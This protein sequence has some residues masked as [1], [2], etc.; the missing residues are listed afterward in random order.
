[1]QSHA[2]MTPVGKHEISVRSMSRAV[3]V[4]IER[5]HGLHFMRQITSDRPVK[6]IA[7]NIKRKVNATDG[8]ELSRSVVHS[9]CCQRKSLALIVCKSLACITRMAA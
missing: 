1:M 8:C 4:D 5:S 3:C 6:C 2:L 7:F 9:L